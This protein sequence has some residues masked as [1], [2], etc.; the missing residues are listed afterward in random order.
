MI[1]KTKIGNYLKQLRLN[2]KR[3]NDG[4]PFTQDDL[5][6]E[7]IDRGKQISINAIAEWEKG[8]TLPSLDNLEILAEIYNRSIDELLDG[9]NYVEKDYNKTYL[10]SDSKWYT[11]F[12]EKTNIYIIRNKKIQLITSKFKNL[13][14][15]RLNRLFTTNEEKEFKFL[16][17]NFYQ[18]TNYINNY[19]ILN[20]DDKYLKLKNAIYE[21][22]AKKKNNSINEKYWEI[23]KFFSE[24]KDIQFHFWND[25]Y[26]LKKVH[27]LKE[28]F[29]NLDDWQKDMLLAMFQNIEPY[30]EDPSKYGSKFYKQYENRHGEYNHDN[31]LKNCIKEL[32]KQG[33]CI[34]KYFL[35]YRLEEKKSKR[36]IDRLEELYNLCIKSFEIDFIDNNGEIKSYLVE[37]NSKNRFLKNYYSQLKYQLNGFNSNENSNEDVDE[38]YH[39][40]SDNNEISDNVYLKIAKKKNIDTTQEKKYWMADVKVGNSL[41]Q[42]FKKYKEIEKEIS[43]GLIEIKKLEAKL[44]SDEIYYDIYSSRIIGGNDED[45]IRNYIEYWKEKLDYSDYL[46]TRNKKLTLELLNDLNILSLKEIKDKY[47]GMEVYIKDE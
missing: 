24:N 23:Q 8:K 47:F 13:L 9:E 16:V 45:S 11:K 1:N 14:K 37:N 6:N 25:V 39:W 28:R 34:N 30:N 2:K 17:S 40:F 41:E 4:K 10:I 19:S 7:F 20:I 46:K 5:A 33:A 18:I 26:D 38:I 42:Y 44:D 27:I 31:E 32:I 21:M 22:I 36:I 29:K 3:E 43:N 12:D 15:I 35:N